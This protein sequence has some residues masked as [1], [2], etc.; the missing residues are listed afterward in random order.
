MKDIFNTPINVGDTVAFALGGKHKMV[1]GEVIKINPKTITVERKQD[2]Y[3]YKYTLEYFRAPENV[4]VC[5]AQ[6]K[7]LKEVSIP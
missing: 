4:V 1:V 7:V 5:P 2:G 3:A 6:P